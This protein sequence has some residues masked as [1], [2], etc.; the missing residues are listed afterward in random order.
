[1]KVPHWLVLA[2]IVLALAACQTPSK[3]PVERGRIYFEGLGCAKCHAIGEHGGNWGPNLTFVGVRKSP[4]WLDLWLKDPHAW[5]KQTIMPSFHLRDDVRSDL[6]A[7]LSA[8]K[9]QAWDKGGVRPWN[10]PQAKAEGGIKRGE[11][12][13]NKAGCVACHSQGGRGGY[14]NNNVA[15][16]Q[17]PALIKVAEGYSKP[18]LMAKIR[19]GAI[20]IPADPSKPAPMIVMPKWGQVLDNDEIG[21]V[22]DYLLSLDTAAASA[23]QSGW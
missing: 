5:R 2:S 1:M 22:A 12:L 23:D 21:A 6:V 18:E 3:D 9:G 10:T 13:F 8:Q 7:F 11:I 14:P 20:P 15:G 16:G 17:I 4:Q 19:D